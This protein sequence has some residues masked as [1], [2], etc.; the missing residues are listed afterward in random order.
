M[1]LMNDYSQASTAYPD[2]ARGLA[3]SNINQLW[4]ADIT[5]VRLRRESVFLSVI[6]D[7][8]SRRCP[9]WALS[10]RFDT[11]LPL[12]AL[13][14]ALRTRSSQPGLVHHSDHA[15]HYA[16]PDYVALLQEHKIQISMGREVDPYDNANSEP[17]MHTLKNEEISQ[18]G[19]ETLADISASAQHFIQ[20]VYDQKRPYSA[21]SSPPADSI[22]STAAMTSGK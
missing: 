2:L 12:A 13:R 21:I 22:Q 15:V 3:R 5:Y 7:D 9:G 18:S 1:K 4:V 6:L 17:F 8:Y 19:Y 11:Q 14:M 16:A 20:A 10:R